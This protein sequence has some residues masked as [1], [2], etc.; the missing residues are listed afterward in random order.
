MGL[1]KRFRKGWSAGGTAEGRDAKLAELNA[2]R[3][4][5]KTKRQAD[6]AEH[7]QRQAEKVER[8]RGPRP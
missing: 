7:K 1:L 8:M 2:A 3:D 6:W 5:R 4:E